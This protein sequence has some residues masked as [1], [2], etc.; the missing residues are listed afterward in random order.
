MTWLLS[1]MTEPLDALVAVLVVLLGVGPML[2]ACLVAPLVGELLLLRGR[3]ALPS[4]VSCLGVLALA[5]FVSVTVLGAGSLDADDVSTAGLGFAGLWIW[6]ALLAWWTPRAQGAVAW[7]T[8]VL[9]PVV[10]VTT[11]ALTATP[12]PWQAPERLVL[13]GG[14]AFTG[15]VLGVEAG[16][17]AV[18]LHDEREVMRWD[19][20]RLERQYC[21]DGSGVRPACP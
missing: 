7:S 11:Y 10:A 14:E 17:A 18:L 15:Y 13:D 3:A 2:T 1:T 20:D 4:V 12:D 5:V 9:G 16:T 21:G 8:L 6:G 19:L